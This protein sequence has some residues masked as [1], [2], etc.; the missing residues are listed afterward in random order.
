VAGATRLD[1][2][3]VIV[4]GASAGIGVET[5][6]VLALMGAKVIMACRDLTKAALTKS[7]I[8]NET[9]KAELTHLMQL[10]LASLQSVKDFVAEFKKQYKALDIL[11]LNAGLVTANRSETADGFETMLGVNHY[12][13]FALTLQLIDVIKAGTTKRI[14]SVSSQAASGATLDFDDLQWKTRPWSLMQAYGQSKLANICFANELNEKLKG[15]GISV[16]SLH[17]GFIP[18]DLSRE[19]RWVRIIQILVYPWTKN[20][21]QGAATTIHAAI[22]NDAQLL[23]GGKYLVDC[24]IQDMYPEVTEDRQKKLWADSVAKTGCDYLDTSASASSATS[25]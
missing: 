5:A 22:D 4:T 19:T 14:I 20:I 11:I 13:H 8:D 10:D 15:T 17:P 3:V 24:K 23:Q 1:G 7:A 16:N 21:P 6:R 12:G 9:G 18:T 25:Q 2:R